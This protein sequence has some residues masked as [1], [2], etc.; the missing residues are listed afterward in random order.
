MATVSAPYGL[1]AIN[2]IGGTPYAGSTRLLPITLAA[3]DGNPAVVNATPIFYGSVVNLN[4]SGTV[5]VQPN[6]GDP[7][8]GGGTG[9]VFT[10]GVIG[11]F[12]GCTYSDPTTGNQ[13]F[14]QYWPGNAATDA[15]AYVVDDPDVCFQIQ[16]AGPITNLQLGENFHFNAVQS[17][18]TATGNSTT[19]ATVVG[20]FATTATFPF[21][22]IDFVDGPTSTIGDA[23]TDLICKFN[24]GIHSYDAGLG[25]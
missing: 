4:A 12:V 24:A 1:R 8:G 22:L 25:V 9:A 15:Q 20:N 2:H 21:R 17:G 19:A 5:I 23:F 11:V 16:A 13:T 6:T 10:A 7:G 18:N 3:L 14:S